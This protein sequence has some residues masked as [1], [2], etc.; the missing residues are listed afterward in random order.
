MR[1]ADTFLGS[2]TSSELSLVSR[3]WSS[4]TSSINTI[5]RA[6]DIP[7]LINE[8]LHN[9]DHY[10]RTQDHGGARHLGG[11]RRQGLLH[12]VCQSV[13]LMKVWDVPSFESLVSS[14]SWRQKVAESAGTLLAKLG[15][16]APTH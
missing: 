15:S 14:A 9:Q 3:S 12:R 4:H 8:E 11:K 6:V 7:D 1:E 13:N 5:E 10:E 16:P 2:G